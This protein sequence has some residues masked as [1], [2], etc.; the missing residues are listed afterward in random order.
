MIE[1]YTTAEMK[2]IWSEEARLQTWFAIELAQA[3]ARMQM[4]FVPEDVVMRLY[5]QSGTIDWTKFSHRMQEHE[6][7]LKH[8]VIAFLT[9]LEEF[10]G[11]DAKV[12]HFGMTSSDVVDTA[13]ALSLQKSGRQILERLDVFE[14]ALMYQAKKYQN[15]VCLGRTHGQAAEITTFGLKLL[16]YVAEVK[17]DK[18]RLLRAI[19]EISHAKLSGAVG[20]YGNSDPQI[21]ARVLSSLGLLV[22]P[23]STQIVPRD[24][25]AV[26]FN[27]L[28]VIGGCLERLAVEIR[29][30][31]RSEVGEAFEPFGSKQRGSSA[32]PHKKNPI[33]TENVTGLARL[34]RSYAGAAL[35]DQALWHERDISHSSVERVIGPDATTVLDFALVRMTSVIEGLVVDAERMRAHVDAVGEMIYSESVMLKLVEKGLERQIAY[36]YVQQAAFESRQEHKRFLYCLAAHLEIKKYLTHQDISDL[37][38]H[39]HHLRHVQTIFDRR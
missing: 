21:E 13:F 7:E 16:S 12:L 15:T 3:K 18:E 33:L 9:T 10:I 28:A 39:D 31:M 2:S 38:S 20:N 1:R 23:V 24:R 5:Q 34:L 6:R 4:G 22:E 29:H 25:H 27:T 8:D 35:E 37:M 14:K 11:E 26:F 30:L 17:R 19:E 32:M 36:G